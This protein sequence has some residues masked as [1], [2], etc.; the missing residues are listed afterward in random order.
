MSDALR[1][2]LVAPQLRSR[3]QWLFLQGG[4]QQVNEWELLGEI[5]KIA[6]ERGIEV[7]FYRKQQSP[8]DGRELIVEY[9]VRQMLICMQENIECR[10]TNKFVEEVVEAG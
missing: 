4:S 1:I 8:R 2:E 6:K 9:D 7:Q 5:A 10:P 3:A